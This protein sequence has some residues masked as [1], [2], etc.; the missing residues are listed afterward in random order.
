MH[1]TLDL[2]GLKMSSLPLNKVYILAPTLVVYDVEYT[3][4]NVNDWPIAL[5]LD[6][7]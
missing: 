2:T 5:T 3:R 7:R 1:V 6:S 4:I